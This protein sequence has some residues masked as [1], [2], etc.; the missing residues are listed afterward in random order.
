M[1]KFFSLAAAL[2]VAMVM[3]VSCGAVKSAQDGMEAG[4]AFANAYTTAGGDLAQIGAAYDAVAKACTPYAADNVQT[5]MFMGGVLQSAEEKSADCAGA[6]LGL[7][8]ATAAAQG[9]D[10]TAAI[11]ALIDAA[12]DKA[13]VKA[14]YDNFNAN[15]AAAQQ[16]AQEA[17][18]A[19][20]YDED[21]EEEEG[22]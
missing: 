17:A 10:V 1:K 19:E 2:V 13:A 16:A 18:E 12:K 5:A 3:M 22:E 15:L 14:A 6:F 20:E 4:K 8:N 21:V 9:A 11:N 7:Y